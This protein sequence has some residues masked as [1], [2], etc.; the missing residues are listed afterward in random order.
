MEIPNIKIVEASPNLSLIATPNIQVMR[1]LDFTS[2][3]FDAL[4]GEKKVPKGRI[5]PSQKGSQKDLPSPSSLW[6]RGI[7]SISPKGSQKD[8]A[9]LWVATPSQKG[10]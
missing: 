2:E 4:Q 5:S 3:L 9:S 10:S 6:K 1:S 7:T 8:L